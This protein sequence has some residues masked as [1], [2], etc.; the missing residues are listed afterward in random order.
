MKK[1]EQENEGSGSWG[2]ITKKRKEIG[3]WGSEKEDT[4]WDLREGERGG[5]RAQVNIGKWGSLISG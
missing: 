1:Q 4:N 5:H 2:G 3:V